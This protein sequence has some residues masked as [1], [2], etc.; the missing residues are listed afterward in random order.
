MLKLNAISKYYKFGDSREC[1]LNNVH[2]SVEA[3]EIVALVGPSGSGKSTLLQIAGLLDTPVSGSVL[4][5]GVNCSNLN[6]N[7][8]T[9]IRR[10][11]IGFV[12]QFHHLMPDFSV[13]NN[14]ILPKLILGKSIRQAKKE[15]E[16]IIDRLSIARVLNKN[17]SNLSG[18]ERQRVAIARAFANEPRLILAD[19]PTGNLDQK[20]SEEVFLLLVEVVRN[21]GASV[22]IVTH[23]NNLAK[24]TDKILHM[25]SLVS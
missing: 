7:Q 4:F 10:E 12:Y 19:E 6:D 21:S 15:V 3:G 14:I 20:N 11:S 17:V 2:L 9:K 5:D 23:D 22:V 18:G 16:T 8:R 1:I 25:K 24:Q 13:I